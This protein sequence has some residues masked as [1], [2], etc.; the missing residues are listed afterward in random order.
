MAI[1]YVYLVNS[2]HG[3]PIPFFFFFYHQLSSFTS[4]RSCTVLWRSVHL[5]RHQMDHSFIPKDLSTRPFVFLFH[6]VN[7]NYLQLWYDAEKFFTVRSPTPTEVSWMDRL[8]RARFHK[9]WS[10]GTSEFFDTLKNF[11][12]SRHTYI[13]TRSLW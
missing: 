13:T 4:L 10:S 12:P 2:F 1:P 7:R 9:G 5:S 8:D 6:D 11:D 3:F